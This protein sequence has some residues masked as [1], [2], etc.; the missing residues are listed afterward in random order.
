MKNKAP[1]LIKE[2]RNCAQILDKL[3]GVLDKHFNIKISRTFPPVV[4]RGLELG[5]NEF[6][7]PGSVS[8]LRTARV[9]RSAMMLSSCDSVIDKCLSRRAKWNR[10]CHQPDSVWSQIDSRHLLH[11]FRPPGR[12]VDSG[13]TK[14]DGCYSQSFKNVYS[15]HVNGFCQNFIIIENNNQM[16]L[17]IT[18][19]LKVLKFYAYMY[20]MFLE[21]FN[22][23][24]KPVN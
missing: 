23:I 13:P 12:E 17:H 2:I 18:F 5:G 10:K 19:F 16:Q 6:L 8:Q 1:Y 22:Q 11:S 7:A 20:I 3:L 24:N 4:R 14:S 9:C 15:L 21:Y